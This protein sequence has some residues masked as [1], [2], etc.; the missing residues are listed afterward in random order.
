MSAQSESNIV[1]SSFV[2][3]ADLKPSSH[4]PTLAAVVTLVCVRDHCVLPIFV[5][6]SCIRSS[7]T[8]QLLGTVKGTTYKSTENFKFLYFKWVTFY[9]L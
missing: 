7:V 1:L 3:G 4:T 6:K 2:P 9:G 8:G 5:Q